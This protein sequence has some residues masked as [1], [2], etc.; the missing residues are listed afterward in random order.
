MNIMVLKGERE[1][2]REVDLIKI[3]YVCIKF[4]ISKQS[5]IKIL[6]SI[7]ACSHLMKQI[8]IQTKN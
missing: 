8:V 1:R 2:E 7:T 3:V 4:S 6:V 5:V